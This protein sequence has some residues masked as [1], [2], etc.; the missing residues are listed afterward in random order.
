M[1]RSSLRGKPIYRQPRLGHAA[2]TTVSA[3]SPSHSP[4]PCR[5][6]WQAARA[7]DTHPETPLSATPRTTNFSSTSSRSAADQTAN[8]RRRSCN[9]LAGLAQRIPGLLRLHTGVPAA[10]PFVVLESSVS[11]DA[12]AVSIAGGLHDSRPVCELKQIGRITRCVA[13]LRQSHASAVNFSHG[14]NV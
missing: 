4:P 5:G 11:P 10:K 8:C 12:R 2:A 9:A 3:L 7:D 13:H 6:G 14:D 1:V